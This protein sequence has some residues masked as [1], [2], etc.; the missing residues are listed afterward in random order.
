M[1]A[2]HQGTSMNS[3]DEI[4]VETV[5]VQAAMNPFQTAHVPI[6]SATFDGRVRAAAK[7]H[8]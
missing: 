7:K 2:L 3:A 4:A 6:R 5:F 8:L 1:G